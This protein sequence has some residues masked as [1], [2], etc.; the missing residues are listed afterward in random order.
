M[1]S[2][3]AY[4]LLD[5]LGATAYANY[6]EQMAKMRAWTGGLSEE[7]WNET[8]YNGWLYT[9][10]ALLPVPG[11]GYPQFM[12]SNAWLDKQLST[13]LGSWAELKHDT[14]LYAKQVYAELGGGGD[15]PPLPIEAQGY[16]EPVPEFYARL[17]ALATMTHDGL[18][19]RGLLSERDADSLLRLIQL[20][21]AFQ[22]M[23]EKELRGEPLDEGELHLI[24][25]YGGELE[26][27]VMAA[28]D[29]EGD[30]PFAMPVMEEEPQAAV[31]ADVATAPDPDGD[32]IPNPV[33]LEVGVGR[34]DELYVVVPVIRSDGSVY[35]Q[36]AKGGVFAYYEFP[37]PADDRL[38]DE[39]WRAMLDAG[40]APE[41]PSWIG[42]F[43][44]PETENAA[45]Q[46]AVYNFQ[47]GITEYYWYRELPYNWTEAVAPPFRS[48]VETLTSANEYV[49]RQWI[50]ASYRSFD[51]Q[52]PN[53]AVVTVRETWEDT[54][55]AQSTDYPSQGDAVLA[56]RG[57]YT[58]DVTYTL[59][60]VDGN[61]QVTRVVL[62]SA[63][64][65][66]NE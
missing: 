29:V 40:E 51:L 16:V 20:V 48:D 36:V 22:V 52:A 32:G 33:A 63:P 11:D 9:L 34:I 44:T 10:Q 57:P 26:H 42:G 6:P 31:I 58:L 65:A 50:T 2:E 17:S 45:V 60:R 49:G 37:W 8:L 13:S 56:Q 12:R 59:E 4:T 25:F 18:Q 7:E 1:G 24:R 23:A 55:Y 21:D 35:L 41:R 53:L 66:W 62:N 46:R 5:E 14:I 30:D 3:R 15:G 39:K 28:S 61:W 64:P 54:R 43:F 47:R 19:S 27:L 38:T